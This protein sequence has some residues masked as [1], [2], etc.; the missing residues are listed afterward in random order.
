MIR[1]LRR[2]WVALRVEQKHSVDGWPQPLLCLLGRHGDHCG[3]CDPEIP[4]DWP[5]WSPSGQA[6]SGVYR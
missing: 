1:A 3:W 4:P 5:R 6:V 2:F